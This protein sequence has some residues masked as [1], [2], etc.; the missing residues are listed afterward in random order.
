M[1]FKKSWDVAN[2]AQQINAAAYECISPYNDG[3]TS[4]YTKQDL[5]RI[6]W[7]IDDA[8]KRCP[9]YAGEDEWLREQEKKRVIKILKDD[10]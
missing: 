5:Y 1:G 9:T 8:L 4:F 3:Y 10:I 6:K 7:L 2:I